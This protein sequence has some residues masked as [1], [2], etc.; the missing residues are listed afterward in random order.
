MQSGGNM[1]ALGRT[2]AIRNP[3]TMSHTERNVNSMFKTFSLI[4]QKLKL[5]SSIGKLIP[6]VKLKSKFSKN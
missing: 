4:K 3:V 2:F 5:N 6:R 1:E